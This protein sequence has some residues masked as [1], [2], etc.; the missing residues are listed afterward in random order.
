[1]FRKDPKAR[2]EWSENNVAVCTDRQRT[3]VMDV[4]NSLK[5]GGFLIYSTCTFNRDENEDNVQW[6]MEQTGAEI[7]AFKGGFAQP[8]RAGLGYYALPHQLDTEGFYFSILQ[9]TDDSIVKKSKPVASSLNVLTDTSAFDDLV[10]L[11]KQQLIQWTDYVFAIPS[12]FKDLIFQLHTKLRL[13]KMGTEC[14][15]LIRKGCIPNVAL[16]LDYSC[17]SPKIQSFQISKNEALSYLHGDTFSLEGKQGFGIMKYE[18]TSL[19]FI[20]HLGNRFNNIYPKEWRIRMR[21]D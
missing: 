19:G 5:N 14:G 9:K 21:V 6:I 12:E 1:M 15:E 16:A 18:N 10:M 17:C 13:I 7:V 2:N 3:I 11:N 8:D 4:W 20:K